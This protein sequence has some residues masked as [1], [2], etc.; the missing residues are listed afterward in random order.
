MELEIGEDVV[1]CDVTA[2][3]YY[4]SGAADDPSEVD[5]VK[6]VNDKGVDITDWLAAHDQR[7]YAWV[8]NRLWE[9]FGDPKQEDPDDA[10]ERWRDEEDGR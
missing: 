3:I 4:G 1:V 5:D 8:V 2:S 6:I 10:Y 7:T 9:E